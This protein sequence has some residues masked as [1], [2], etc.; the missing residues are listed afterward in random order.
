MIKIQ[1]H[2]PKGDSFSA[3]VA[4]VPRIGDIVTVA[5][6]MYPVENVIHTIADRFTNASIVVVLGD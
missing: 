4:A 3:E 6:S 2:M 5:M 1:I